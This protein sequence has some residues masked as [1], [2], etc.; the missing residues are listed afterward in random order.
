[1]V[2]GDG[3]GVISSSKIALSKMSSRELI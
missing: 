3:G 1:M 2:H